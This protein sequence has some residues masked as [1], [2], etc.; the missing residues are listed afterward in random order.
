MTLNCLSLGIG[1][2]HSLR[3]GES[4]L[5]NSIEQVAKEGLPLGKLNLAVTVG[6]ESLEELSDLGLALFRCDLANTDLG[7]HSDL[8]EL[9]LVDITVAVEIKLLESLTGGLEGFGTSSSDSCGVTGH[10]YKV[11]FYYNTKNA[12]CKPSFC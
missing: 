6:I 9:I 7:L 10:L 12:R 3:R 4:L 2:A 11:R 8:S 5:H 1:C